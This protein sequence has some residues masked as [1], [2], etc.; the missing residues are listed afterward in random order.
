MRL[1][2]SINFLVGRL[3]GALFFIGQ[4]ARYGRRWNEVL[5]TLFTVAESEDVVVVAIVV[6][7]ARTFQPQGK[8]LE[9][10]VQRD[11]TLQLPCMT[12]TLSVWVCQFSVTAMLIPF[13]FFDHRSGR[14]QVLWAGRGVGLGFWFGINS[15]ETVT[16]PTPKGGSF[17]PF[18][19]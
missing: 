16:L 18:Y 15:I 4:V 14:P 12:L 6:H 2:P 9:V 1:L 8:A 11:L 19:N 3:H 7:V 17:F 13:D 10:P 5:A